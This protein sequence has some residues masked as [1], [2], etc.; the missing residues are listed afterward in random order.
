MNLKLERFGPFVSRNLQGPIGLP[1]I[2]GGRASPLEI[3]YFLRM[4]QF[5][6][7]YL[8]MLIS[9]TTGCSEI[10]HSAENYAMA[11][12]STIHPWKC[13]GAFPRHHSIYPR[14]P[15]DPI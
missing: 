11:V 9:P 6:L 10:L 3:W 5:D 1:G 12:G 13:G 15:E 7:I 8:L 4:V 14:D 2:P